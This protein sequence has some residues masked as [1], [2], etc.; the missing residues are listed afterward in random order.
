MAA[1]ALVLVAALAAGCAGPAA[2]RPQ[3][4]DAMAGD[5]TDV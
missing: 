1:A 4:G 3:A 5:A 2:D